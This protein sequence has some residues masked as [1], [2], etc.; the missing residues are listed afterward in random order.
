MKAMSS[1][2]ANNLTPIKFNAKFLTNTINAPDYFDITENSWDLDGVSEALTKGY[3][4]C[5]NRAS[6]ITSLRDDSLVN[7]SADK[8]IVSES[9]GKWFG[10]IY[11]DVADFFDAGFTEISLWFRSFNSNK[12]IDEYLENASGTMLNI[13]RGTFNSA[14]MDPNED[15]GY[16][17]SNRFAQDREDSTYRYLRL[18]HNEF[19][20]PSKN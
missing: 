18:K 13:N 4:A 5:T 6:R 11:W 7:Q 2:K 1:K 20:S 15:G 10:D 16:F 14:C 19:E 9:L 12:S 17:T 3:K 8:S